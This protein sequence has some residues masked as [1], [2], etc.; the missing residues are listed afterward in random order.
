[1]KILFFA[2]PHLQPKGPATRKD[3]YAD[4]IL[5]KLEQISA[6]TF[7][8]GVDLTV[9]LGDLFHHK[10]PSRTPYW[11]LN[12]T[13]QI[14][15]SFDPRVRI[16]LGNHDLQ[17]AGPASL[18]RQPVGVLIE[19]GALIHGEDLEINGRAVTFID[20][21]PKILAHLREYHTV[22]HYG[23]V[24]LT[25]AD[26][27]NDGR[28]GTIS[29]DE[30]SKWGYDYIIYGHMHEFIKEKKVRKTTFLSVPTVSRGAIPT[31]E[32]PKHPA[33]VTVDFATH[34][35]KFIKLQAAKKEDI[36][37]YAAHEL[38]KNTMHEIE[39]FVA[40]AS[41]IQ[42]KSGSIAKALE[43]LKEKLDPPVYTLMM[44]YLEDM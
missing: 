28:F 17:S 41:D 37:D 39:T 8:E 43:Q 40:S 36:F 7:T 2:D 21:Q 25:H 22:T 12:K 30:A 10:D 42:L 11:L 9:C 18:D 13:Y 32:D 4:A 34:E 35:V 23:G 14:L 16:V 27:T 1:M 20:H 24:L 6:L 26:I 33:V 19:A 5:G 31:I 3:N 44:T 29:W 38:K 15:S